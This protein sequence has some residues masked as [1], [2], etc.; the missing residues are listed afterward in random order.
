MIIEEII[1]E[2]DKFITKY[3]TLKSDNQILNQ[4]KSD[5]KTALNVKGIISTNEDSEV[6]PSIT[7]YAPPSTG[8]GTTLDVDYL[9]KVGLLPY[10]FSGTPTEKDLLVNKFLFQ[11]PNN[12]RKF[13]S[14]DYLSNVSVKFNEEVTNDFRLARSN[15]TSDNPSIDRNKYTI[16]NE[17]Y[18]INEF[19]FTKPGTYKV[20]VGTSKF[21][22]DKVINYTQEAITSMENYLVYAV[23][24]KSKRFVCY[25]T[26]KTETINYFDDT[27]LD[28]TAASNY[29]NV[30]NNLNSLGTNLEKFGYVYNLRTGKA[31]LLDI[32]WDTDISMSSIPQKFK[33]GLS[34]LVNSN[35]I[36][37]VLRNYLFSLAVNGNTPE[38][39]ISD[40]DYQDG[41][42][43]VLTLFNRRNASESQDYPT[44]SVEEYLKTIASALS[45]EEPTEPDLTD[46]TV[47]NYTEKMDY[48]VGT[49]DLNALQS[50]YSDYVTALNGSI[51]EY[52]KGVVFS[53]SRLEY[54]D[55]DPDYYQRVLANLSYKYI[56]GFKSIVVFDFTNVFALDPVPLINKSVNLSDICR[57]A[58]YVV[59][60]L[61]KD[62]VYY[63][64][65]DRVVTGQSDKFTITRA[66]R[67]DGKPVMVAVNND[68]FQPVSGELTY[69]FSSD[70]L[71]DHL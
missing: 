33:Y 49:K 7:N 38:T 23:N 3:K 2:I 24:I 12:E 45:S 18:Y 65:G 34:T 30:V 52:D 48:L 26:N 8:G 29:N 10:N 66:D 37:I 41:D 61:A 9:K 71:G 50:D 4:F 55:N 69:H 59:F 28:S 64:D 19:K 31:H 5:V 47:R 67:V 32:K 57:G 54:V 22:L 68:G 39:F 46:V 20:S 17:G 6:I 13:I 70:T 25:D 36:I 53:F 14:S 15:T 1:N 60:K 62:H 63:K 42:T 51:Y 58:G 16:S 56:K 40:I 43:L 27:T 35:K 44:T 11:D 21:S